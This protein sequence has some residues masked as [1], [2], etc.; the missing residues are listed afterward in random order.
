MAD[1][2]RKKP[3][4]QVVREVNPSKKTITEGVVIPRAILAGPHW[5]EVFQPSTRTPV[6]G[7][8][9]P[10]N[11]AALYPSP[12][13]LSGNRRRGLQHGAGH[14][15]LL[16]SSRPMRTGPFNARTRGH[17][18]AGNREE[19]RC[20]YCWAVPLSACPLH[21]RARTQSLRAFHYYAP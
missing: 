6:A 21:P 3:A 14:V 13:S 1:R 5:S 4:L 9:L 17:C 18:R 2:Y 19:R 12:R 10:L 8:S 20:H 15:C 7:Q 11:G 16:G